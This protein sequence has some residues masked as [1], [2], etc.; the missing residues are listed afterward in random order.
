VNQL[1]SEKSS[2][3]GCIR[4]LESNNY[5]IERRRMNMKG[6]QAVLVFIVLCIPAGVLAQKS[7]QTS[8]VSVGI[9]ENARPVELKQNNTGKGVVVGTAVGALRNSNNRTR[10][11]VTGAVVGGAVGKA[12][13]KSAS[14]ME[15]AIR[16]GPNNVVTVVSNQTQ[17]HVGDCVSVQQSGDSVNVSRIDPNECAKVNIQ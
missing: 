3:S 17:I 5:F 9:V 2:K 11:V 12:T 6:L 16:T 13:S 8:Q 14:G 10:S 7:V 1:S 4:L 15:Y